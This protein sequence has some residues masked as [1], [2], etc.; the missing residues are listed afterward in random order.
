M[1]GGWLFRYFVGGIICLPGFPYTMPIAFPSCG[2]YAITADSHDS[3]ETLTLAVRAA[4]RGGARV[5]QYRVKSARDRLAEA[6]L[7][8]AECRAADVPL[9]VNDDIELALAVGADGVHL[10]Q[11]DGSL[12]EARARLGAKALIGVSCYDSPQRAFD[13]ECQGADYVAFGRFFPSASKPHAPLAHLET[14]REAKRQ[15]HVPIV[16]IGGITADNGSALLEAGADLL[17]VIDAVFGVA[18]PEHAARAF[19]SL[20]QGH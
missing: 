15:L 4:L 5:I 20:F 2:L 17:A 1:A 19:Q 7:L 13:V 3:P 16:A 6:R 14:L 11:D 18:D 9:I 10:G 8:L 12:A